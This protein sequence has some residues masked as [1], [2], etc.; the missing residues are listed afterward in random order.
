MKPRVVE[1]TMLLTI[2]YDL[3][4]QFLQLEFRDGAIYHYFDVPPHV[5][6]GLISAPSKGGYFNRTIRGRFVHV[7]LKATPSL[8]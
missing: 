6:Q 4:R 8:S 1:S 5:Y 2:A 7:R 3:D